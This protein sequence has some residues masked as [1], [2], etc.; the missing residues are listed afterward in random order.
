MYPKH[1]AFAYIPAFLLF[2]LSVD[3]ISLKPGE[4][5]TITSYYGKTNH[6]LNVP[7]IASRILQPGFG[8]YKQ[9]RLRE[10]VNQITA[11]GETRTSH[12]LFDE[13]IKQMF[14]DSSL[15]GGVPTLLGEV[16]DGALMRN[17]D[18]DNR[19]KVYHLFSRIHGDLERDYN[20]FDVSPTFFSEVRFRV[21][22]YCFVFLI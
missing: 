4:S 12:H 3:S 15:N 6:V 8:P 22:G 19:L 21:M 16:D 20:D 10:I 9:T 5:V 11:I 13:Y 17:T 2:F 14:L 18:E 7:V 1:F